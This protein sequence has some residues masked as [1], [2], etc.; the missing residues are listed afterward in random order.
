VSTTSGC[1]SSGLA[2]E[3]EPCV[4]PRGV[5]CLFRVLGL[6]LRPLALSPARPLRRG[7]ASFESLAGP[8]FVRFLLPRTQLQRVPFSD[9][10]LLAETRVGRELPRSRRCR[11][12]GSCPS[13][14][15]QLVHGSLEVFWTPP[16]AVS[17]P[18]FAALFHAARVTGA[19]LQ[20]FPFPRSRTRS[21]G[22]RASLRVRVR[23]PPAQCLQ[24]LHDR[25]PRSRRPFAR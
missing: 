17:P 25:F 5:R 16:I 3:R 8:P 7:D 1:S 24:E 13:R 9:M 4:Y 10:D 21:R 11:P 23:L 18:C 20:S 2:A 22:P 19:S 12:Q 15:F 6:R 14:R